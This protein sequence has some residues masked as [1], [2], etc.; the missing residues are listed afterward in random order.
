MTAMTAIAAMQPPAASAHVVVKPAE[1]LSAE[2]ETFTVSV[3]NEKNVATVSIKLAIP[4]GLKHVSPTQKAGWRITVDRTGADSES[5]VTAITWSGSSIDV[6]L[7]DT[8]NFS[9]QAPAATTTL[10][11]RAYQTYA[12]GTIVSWDKDDAPTSDTNSGP[13][14]IT[15]VVKTASTEIANRQAEQIAVDAQQTADIALY[16]ASASAIAGLI[17]IYFATRRQ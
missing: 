12:D 17:G 10:K 9:A 1:T 11:W 7:R 14:S 3:P 2:F 4:D 16:I 5:P 13:L 8:F 6:G 15:N